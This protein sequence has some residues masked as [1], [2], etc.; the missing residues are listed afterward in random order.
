M[1]NCR[2]TVSLC[3]LN[4][5]SHTTYRKII[6]SILRLDTLYICVGLNHTNIYHL[7]DFEYNRLLYALISIALDTCIINS[8]TF[9][10]YYHYTF[11]LINSLK[12]PSQQR[13][14]SL[15]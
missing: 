4:I 1:S 14:L 15:N 7:P 12:L 3:L 2:L 5:V 9:V 13:G 6:H 8:Q 10:N 11:K